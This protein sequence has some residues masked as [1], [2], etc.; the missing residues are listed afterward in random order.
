MKGV[1]VSVDSAKT[2]YA[3][4]FTDDVAILKDDLKSVKRQLFWATALA[5]I[6]AV[7]ALLLASA[8]ILYVKGAN[9]PQSQG[10]Q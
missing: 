2:S 10:T 7:S 3:S 8:A 6:M 4:Y 1:N 9:E 5:L